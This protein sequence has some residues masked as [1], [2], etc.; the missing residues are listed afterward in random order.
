MLRRCLATLLAV[1]VASPVFAQDLRGSIQQAV[2][3]TAAQQPE[4]ARSGRIHPALLWT[5]I[6]LLGA[7]GLYLG[8]GAAEDPDTQTCVYSSSSETCVSNRTVL[9]TSGAVMAGVG[10]A[11]LAIGVAKSKH[12]PSVGLRPGGFVVRQSV[13]LHLGLKH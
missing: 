9:L 4:S 8:L 6:G 5:G 13:P 1:L 10:G 11:L 2:N 12:A 3:E 7:G